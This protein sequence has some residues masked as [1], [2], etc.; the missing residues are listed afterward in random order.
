MKQ[1]VKARQ[2]LS[3]SHSMY[4]RSLRATGAALLQF[5]GNETTLSPPVPPN[6]H[7]PPPPPPPMSPGSD[8]WTSSTTPASSA[9]PPPPP[10]PSGGWDFWDPFSHQT[11]VASRSATEEEWE[12]ATSSSDA[13]VVTVATTG[14]ASMAPPPSV[15]SGFSKDTASGSELA[16]VVSRNGKELV[17]IVKE[18]D[19]YFMKAADAGS[20]LSQLLEVS[21]ANFAGHT[22]GGKI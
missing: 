9:L 21:N 16:M 10:P 11:T 22:K 12:A 18:V 14:S 6:P 3:A 4:L 15:V 2:A 5:S 8:A 20:E 1:L 13:A 19:E 17:E 7:L